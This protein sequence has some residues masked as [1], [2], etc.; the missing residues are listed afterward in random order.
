VA[1]GGVSGKVVGIVHAT[2]TGV[3]LIMTTCHVF[4]LMWT[5]V[6]EDT[7]GTIIGADIGGATNVFL[8]GD[9]GRTG[10]AGMI[11]AIGKGG[12]PG[13]SSAISL[14]RYNRDRS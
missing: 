5:R 10:R 14:D 7:T 4:I 3:G 1:G 6:G 11:I 13:A 2:I 9:F 8:T 12:E